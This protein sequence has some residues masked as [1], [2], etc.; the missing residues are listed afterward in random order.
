MPKKLCRKLLK[1]AKKRKIA[2]G[3]IFVT[4][5]GNPIS[6]K[7]VWREMKSLCERAGIVAGI[8]AMCIMLA[9]WS[10][11][12]DSVVLAGYLLLSKVYQWVLGGG[13]LL[14]ALGVENDS[15]VLVDIGVLPLDLGGDGDPLPLFQGASLVVLA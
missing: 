1:Y 12:R 8:V 7:Q 2:S 6:R 11:V 15:L 5:G 3:S 10:L 13:R 9:F 4:G 14:Y